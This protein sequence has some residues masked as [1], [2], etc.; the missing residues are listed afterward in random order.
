[1]TSSLFSTSSDF[2]TNNNKNRFSGMDWN[3]DYTH[4]FKKEG[5]ELS[6]AAQ[7]TNLKA[8]TDFGTYYTVENTR[9]Q[10]GTNE[11]LNDEY[12]FQADFAQPFSSKVKLELGGKLIARRIDSDYDFEKRV[13]NEFVYNDALSNI[14]KYN[15]DVYAGYSVLTFNLKKNWGLQAGGR[16]EHTNIDGNVTNTSQGVLPVNKDYDNFIPSLSISKTVKT[17]SYRLSYSKRI[18][19]PSLQYLN[20]FRNTSNPLTHTMGNPDLSPEV[21]QSLEFNFSTFIKTSVINASLYVRHTD[22]IIENFLTKELY[23]Y[24][25]G[26]SDSVSLSTFQNIGNNNSIGGSLFGQIQPIKKL[27]LRGNVNLFTYQPKVSSQYSASTSNNNKTY[28]MYN[29]FVGGS[30]TIVKGFLMETFAVINAP[31]R[32]AQGKNPSFNM[33]Q[34]SFNKEILKKKGKLGLNVVDPFNERK[35]FS[36]S[37]VGNGLTQ[38]S[39]FSVPFRSIGVNFSYQFGKMNFNPQQSR[40]KRGVNNDDLKQDSGGQG[41]QGGQGT[42]M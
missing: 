25:D 42:G 18:Q 36:S 23:T 38:S 26:H 16:I 21:S 6:L 5:N 24:P 27:T 8:N 2:V 33:W 19:R 13:G 35:N 39:N 17:N 31:R 7:W 3:A 30:Y 10:N 32:T 14:Y 40:K 34:V 4:K 29:A 1:M 41:G 9:D 28:L 15:Q 22:D 12:T 20:P 37:F 11:G